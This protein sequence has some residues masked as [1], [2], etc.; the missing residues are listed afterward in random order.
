MIRRHDTF[1]DPHLQGVHDEIELC[2][3]VELAKIEMMEKRVA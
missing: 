2:A 3:H 1:A